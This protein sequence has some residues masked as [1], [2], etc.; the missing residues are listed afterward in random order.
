MN[1]RKMKRLKDHR[2][3]LHVLK[4]CS[5]TVRKTILNSANP[6]LIK[7]ICEI[8]MNILNGN[9]KISSRSKRSLKDYKNSLRKISSTRT[10]L[11]SKKKILVQK[12][13]FLPTILGAILSGVIGNLIDR[14]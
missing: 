14:I 4:S 6:D 10:S 11:K 8:C 9:V 12:G 5:P 3:I 1:C 13:G 2:H 7:A